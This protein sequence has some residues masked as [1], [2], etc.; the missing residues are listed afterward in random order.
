MLH[1]P[2]LLAHLVSE[3]LYRPVA[4]G[5]VDCDA[6]EHLKRLFAGLKLRHIRRGEDPDSAQALAL[7]PVLVRVIN[8]CQLVSG[9]AIKNSAENDS[10]FAA[11]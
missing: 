6:L 1:A 3:K 7:P 5:A 9:S 11:F 8:Q 10:N 4:A 2:M